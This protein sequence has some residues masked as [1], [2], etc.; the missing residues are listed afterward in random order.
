MRHWEKTSASIFVHGSKEAQ[1]PHQS[2]PL[3]YRNTIFS[4]PSP[5]HS[6]CAYVFVCAALMEDAL[7]QGNDLCVCVYWSE[8]DLFQPSRD[9]RVVH[10]AWITLSI[11][12]P[13]QTT[14]DWAER[15][16]E[17]DLLRGQEWRGC[18]RKEERS[19]KTFKYF[20]PSYPT[21]GKQ[22][23][24]Q[25]F[26]NTLKPQYVTGLEDQSVEL[27]LWLETLW[28]NSTNKVFLNGFS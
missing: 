7:Q 23:P 13:A 5:F 19:R 9:Y 27:A 22:L 20:L 28:I 3:H 12:L 21:C 18:I 26:L 4:F 16:R 10:H 17:R 25:Q 14:R 24:S 6:L 2:L 11:L 15:E 1:T 8:C